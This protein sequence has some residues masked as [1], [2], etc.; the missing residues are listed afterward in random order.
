MFKLLLIAGRG[1]RYIPKQHRRRAMITAA[2]VAK[3]HGPKV[4]RA[5][6]RAVKSAKRPP[7]KP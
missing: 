2:V 4:A 3:R 6:Q 1:W 7:E 5:A